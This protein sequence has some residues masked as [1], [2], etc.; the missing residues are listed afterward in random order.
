MFDHP[1]VGLVTVACRRCQMPLVLADAEIC[2][3]CEGPLCYNCWDKFGHCG[4]AEADK[5]NA[6]AQAIDEKRRAQA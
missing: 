1:A 3:Y 4:H 5:V 6:Q 2:W